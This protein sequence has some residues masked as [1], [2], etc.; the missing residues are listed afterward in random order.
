MPKIWLLHDEQPEVPV[1]RDQQTEEN[2]GGA[3][4]KSSAWGNEVVVMPCPVANVF[5]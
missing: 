2:R 4:Q 5:L 3:K 1:R